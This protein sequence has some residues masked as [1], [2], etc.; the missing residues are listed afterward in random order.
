MQALTRPGN[1]GSTPQ[2]SN[3]AI[4]ATWWNEDIT[5][6][7]QGREAQLAAFEAFHKTNPKTN[8]TLAIV[9]AN[10]DSVTDRRVARDIHEASAR[11]DPGNNDRPRGFT[12]VVDGSE[13]WRYRLAPFGLAFHPRAHFSHSALAQARSPLQSL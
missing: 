10:T 1:E 6:P 3:L 11:R 8:N 9:P 5:E 7:T 2:D 4:Q 13:D 12:D